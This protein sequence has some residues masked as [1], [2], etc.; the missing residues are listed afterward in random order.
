MNLPIE[1]VEG[2]CPDYRNG[3]GRRGGGVRVV[4]LSPM[5]REFVVGQLVYE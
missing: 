4:G 3:T 5:E 2:C 1:E